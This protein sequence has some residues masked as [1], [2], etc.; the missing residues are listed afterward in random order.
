[1]E[2]KFRNFKDAQKFAIS[3]KLKNKNQWADYV[4]INKIPNDIPKAPRSVYLKKG[5]KGWGDWLGT[6]T[7]ASFNRQYKSFHDARKYVHTLGLKSGDQWG[8]YSKSDK[9]PADI[10]AT[11][12]Q[13]YKKEWK[14]WG[15]WL[16]TGRTR[17]HRSFHEARKYVRTLGLTKYDDWWK[18]SRSVTRPSDIPATPEK[19][20]KKEWK[21]MGD[22]LGTFTIPRKDRIYRPF[23]EARNFVRSLNLKGD[24]DWGKFSKSGKRPSDIPSAPW[25]KYRNQ[26]WV[27]M[28]DWLGTFSIASKNRVFKSFREARNFVRS[29][30]LEKQFDWKELCKSGKLPID[31]PTNPW[32]VYKN[33]GWKNMGDWLGTGRIANRNKVWRNFGDAKQFAISLNLKSESEWIKFSK[34]KE[35]PDDIPVAP[36]NT[37]KNKGWKSWGDW[38][39]TGRIAD[40]NKVWRPF[41][42]AREFVRS[43]G[44]KNQYEWAEYCKSGKKPNDISSVPMRIYK[45]KG[46]KNLGDWIGTGRVADRDKPFLSFK[47]AREENR[48]LVKLYGIKTLE[49]WKKAKRLGKIP[50]NIP[51]KP[52]ITYSKDRILRKK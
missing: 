49:D 33:Q 25:E 5:W 12:A 7:I 2:S 32:E 19:V 41:E 44:L 48:R 21:G 17:N 47:E 30:K 18:F 3:L 31:I 11:P 34:S 46:W 29:L 9:K 45:N 38:L 15:D 14:E 51:A 27:S 10:P 40:Q 35:K 6:G 23:I 50:E 26:G 43:L 13:V 20:Y 39:G 36:Y 8:E 52:W 22:W 37:Y 42:K 1:M 16:G 24:E 4:K 28:G